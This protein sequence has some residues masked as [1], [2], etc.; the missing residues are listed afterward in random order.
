ME[1]TQDLSGAYWNN[2]YANNDTGWDMGFVSPPLKQYIDQLADKNIRILIPGCGN[3]Y[4]AAYLAANGFTNITLIDIAP[5]LVQQLQ[6]KFK[7]Q[8]AIKI[9]SGDFFEHEGAYDLILEQTFFCALHSSL[10][11][12]YVRQMH[13][14][15]KQGG[16][17]A[18]VLFGKEFEEQGPPFG[19]SAAEYEELF[20]NYFIIQKAEH[21][22]NSHPKRAG[23]ELFVIFVKR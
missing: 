19:G 10:R 18:G 23:A 1:A 9:I 8:P 12:A 22:Y 15:L 7:G 20:K 4:E 3:S 11:L 13:A 21:C 16:K 6:E 5:L 17:L 2:R 14:L